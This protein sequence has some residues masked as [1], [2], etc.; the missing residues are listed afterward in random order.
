MESS[1]HGL[2]R[3]ILLH[4]ST[5]PGD[6][7]RA[8]A[9]AER[10]VTAGLDVRVEVVVNGEAITGVPG[11]SVGDIPTG[12]GLYACQVAMTAHGVSAQDFASGVVVVSSGVVYL[13][14]RQLD[15]AG[16]IRV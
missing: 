15:G 13:A 9:A 5:A 12:V 2:A 1:Q 10:I 7:P 6:V 3:S 4:A 11:V 14:E 8:L 16:Y